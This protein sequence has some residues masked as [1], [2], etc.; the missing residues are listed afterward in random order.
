MS[1]CLQHVEYD[2]HETIGVGSFGKVKS[3]IHNF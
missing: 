3:N 2:I 1:N